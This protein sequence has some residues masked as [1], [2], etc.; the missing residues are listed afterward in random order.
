[1]TPDQIEALGRMAIAVSVAYCGLAVIA[2]AVWAFLDPEDE[3]EDR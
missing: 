3:E 2:Y 1:M